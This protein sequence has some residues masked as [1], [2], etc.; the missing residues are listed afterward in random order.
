LQAKLETLPNVVGLKREELLAMQKQ[1]ESAEA[2][3]LRI[4]AQIVRLDLQ[5][6]TGRSLPKI[7][8]P[9]RETIIEPKKKQLAEALQRVGV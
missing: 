2:K 8:Y 3:I 6:L 5:E 1:L 4:E 9:V 7:L